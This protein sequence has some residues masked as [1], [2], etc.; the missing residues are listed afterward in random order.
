MD[1]SRLEVSPGVWLDYRRAI[2]L[3]KEKLLAVADL[4]LGYA[5]AHRFKGQ[6]MP[7]QSDDC[8]L[9]R[10]RELCGFYAP[11]RLAIV[12]DIVH[13]AVP[14]AEIREELEL[15]F[16]EL[17]K[18]CGLKLI[19]GTH[20]RKLRRFTKSEGIEF[21][22]KFETDE[23]LLTH[24]NELREAPADKTIIMGHEHPAICLG[25][26]IKSAKFP[27]FLIGRAGTAGARSQILVLPAF[28]YWAAG[29]N[30][31]AYPFMSPLAEKARFA[32]AVA[33]CGTKLLPV[34]LS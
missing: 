33:I 5:W 6:M 22:P 14:V 10:L 27:C 34:N 23:F 3:E 31:R 24:G 12:G 30:I 19:L 15:L 8:L 32:K 25:D 11:D 9:S 4:H 7:L 2:F 26:G 20:D 17:G 13:D 1:K 16:A 18:I 28:S 29:T 21:L